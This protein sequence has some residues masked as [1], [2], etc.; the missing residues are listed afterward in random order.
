M[1]GTVFHY[2]VVAPM[3]DHA[4]CDAQVAGIVAYHER[5]GYKK[6]GAYNGHFCQHGG[7]WISYYGPNQATGDTWANLNL[8]AWCWLGSPDFTPS[9]PALQAAYDLTLVEPTGRDLIYPH[10]VFVQ[11]ACCGDPLRAWITA[12]A[13]PPSSPAPVPPVEE[14][15]LVKILE[16]VDDDPALKGALFLATEVAVSRIG[17]PIYAEALRA[18]GV[19]QQGLLWVQIDRIRAQ[20]AGQVP[21][22]GAIPP[23]THAFAGTTEPG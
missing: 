5:I 1:L 19:Q 23:H 6:G 4:D 14:G 18:M 7:K 3:A 21:T 13:L 22:S 9:D 8:T 12:G 17:D 10:S 11:T 16:A 20:L 15:P 2:A